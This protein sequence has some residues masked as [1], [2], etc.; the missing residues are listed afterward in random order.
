MHGVLQGGWQGVGRES[1]QFLDLLAA[2]V[3]VAAPHL[4]SPFK[5]VFS[6]ENPFPAAIVPSAGTWDDGASG[7]NSALASRVR[8]RIKLSTPFT[9][10]PTSGKAAISLAVKPWR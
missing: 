6:G 5:D 8:R 4:S 1:G 2:E 10:N 3:L 7:F 9:S